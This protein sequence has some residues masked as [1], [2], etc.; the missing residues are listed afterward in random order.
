MLVIVPVRIFCPLDLDELLQPWL[1]LQKVGSHCRWIGISERLRHKLPIIQSRIG[2]FGVNWRQG[3]PCYVTASCSWP[4]ITL[5]LSK[6]TIS[7]RPR[8]V[9]EETWCHPL[10]HT[11]K[12]TR[13]HGHSFEPPASIIWHVQ[14][15]EVV[16]HGHSAGAVYVAG[17]FLA[18][19]PVL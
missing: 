11:L 13:K 19:P 5:C 12:H 2:R 16:C 14:P 10:P 4:V 15:R 17:S 3:P 6:Y 9:G 7:A 8:G 18:S 1:R